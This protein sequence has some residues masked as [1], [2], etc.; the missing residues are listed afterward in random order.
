MYRHRRTASPAR[1]L[2][3]RMGASLSD[4]D[5]PH[6]LELANYLAGRHA[7]SVALRAYLSS[8]LDESCSLAPVERHDVAGTVDVLA[9][10]LEPH[11][12]REPR[13]TP[14]PSACAKR[15]K[16]KKRVASGSHCAGNRDRKICDGL[17]RK[18][19]GDAWATRIE[20]DAKR[21]RAA[22]CAQ[23]WRSIASLTC[24]TAPSRIVSSRRGA[25]ARSIE[26]CSRWRRWR[27]WLR[28]CNTILL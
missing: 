9:P 27:D 14:R 23:P 12:A 26:S 2:I 21:W 16:G 18:A 1:T 25:R 4:L 7:S 6:C 19:H 22:V 11:R 10:L 3:A 13:V 5:G 17:A 15:P 28:Y 20:G 8:R 24:A